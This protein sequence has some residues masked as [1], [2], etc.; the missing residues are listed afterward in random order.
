[1]MEDDKKPESGYVF[2]DAQAVSILQAVFPGEP[3]KAETVCATE[4]S[5]TVLVK[6]MI[7]RQDEQ[8][9][10]SLGY[11]QAEID[12][13]TPQQADDIIKAA[14]KAPDRSPEQTSA[15]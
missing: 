1:M 9:L 10:C 12:R 11:S 13:I 8:D 14:T 2:F 4:A 15:A 6:F 5:K 3:A 7:T